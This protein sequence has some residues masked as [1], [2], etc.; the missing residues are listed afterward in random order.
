MLTMVRGQCNELQIT[1]KDFL[2]VNND[3]KNIS[4]HAMIDIVVRALTG[5]V[6]GTVKRIFLSIQ[7]HD[8][9]TQAV[10]T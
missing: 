5:T 4:F 9:T 8:G 3:S 2:D 10:A 1:S 6:H 7:A